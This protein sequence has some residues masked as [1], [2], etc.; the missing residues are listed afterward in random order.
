MCSVLEADQ[1]TQAVKYGKRRCLEIS[2]G[3]AVMQ[4]RKLE[5][6]SRHKWSPILVKENM[7][8]VVASVKADSCITDI[9][10]FMRDER[11]GCVPV[12]EDG[13]IIGIITDRDITCRAIASGRDPATTTAEAIMTSDVSCCFEDDLLVKAAEIMAE[14]GVRRLPVLN[15]DEE[16]VGL[17]TA[18]DLALHTDHLLL[19]NVIESIYEPHA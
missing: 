5:W 6:K 11:V 1:C 13:K 19:G 15:Q 8:G 3:E 10:Q 9:A 4:K 14:K 16:M 18:D 17:L 12:I 2:N 7:S